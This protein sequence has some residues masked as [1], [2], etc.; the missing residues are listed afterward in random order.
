[1]IYEDAVPGCPQIDGIGMDREDS[2]YVMA[3]PTRVVDGTRYFDFMSETL[4]KATPQ[5]NKVVSS[6]D[7]APVPLPES[8]RPARKPE[9]QNGTLHS[10]WVEGAQW[11]FGGVGFAGFNASQAGGGCACWFSRFS[12]DY[13]ARSIAPEPSHFSVAIL[14]SAGNLITR[15]GRYGNVDSAGARSL[16]PLGGDEVGLV[17]A[18]YVGSHTD[19]RLFISDVGN[20]RIVS[21]K[22]DYHTTERVNLK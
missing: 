17:H 1:M 14:D 11:L 2:I 22:L 19:R 13:F 7:R 12:L 10:A 6:N 18:C 5:K 15:V 3:T 9:L 21:V 4:M 8:E 20:G 16:V